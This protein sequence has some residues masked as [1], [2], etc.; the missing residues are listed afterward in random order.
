MSDARRRLP[1]VNDILIAAEN[2]GILERAPR[3]LVVDAI[4]SVLQR[5]REEGSGEPQGGWIE[6][7]ERDVTARSRPSLTRVVNAT[8]V[9]LHTNLGRAPLSPAAFHAAEAAFGYSALELD[10]ESGNRGSR[11]DHVRSLLQE[12]TGADTGM[13]VTN[14]AAALLLLTSSLAEGGETIVSRSEL[15]E[16]GGSFRIPEI[17]NKSGSVMIEVGT[18]NRTRVKDY[19]LALSPRTRLILKVHQSNFRV[20]GFAEEASV[21]EL[22]ELGRHRGIPTVHDVGSGLLLDLN[23]WG[24]TGEPMVQESVATGA[25]VVFSGDKLLGGPQAGIIVGPSEVIERAA[26]SPLARALR[27]DKLT[28]AALEATL[29]HYRDPVKAVSEIPT[30]AMLTANPRD[31]ADR[32]TKLSAELAGSSTEPGTSAVGG[33][34]FP[35]VEI[36]TTLVRVNTE[37]PDS[38]LESMRRHDPPV[39]ARASEAGVVLDVRTVHDDEFAIIRSAIESGGAD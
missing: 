29:A 1:P 4:R 14:A 8:G 19:Q 18:T 3:R 22:V 23:E 24:L 35:G 21:G 10:L 34:A 11:Q 36:P 16:I 26:A 38:L 17:L 5:A 33:G 6:A 9:V 7:V 30:L 12:I 32:A 28:L 27:P 31:L 15:V 39:I 25:T 2:A 20:I 13:V 37:S